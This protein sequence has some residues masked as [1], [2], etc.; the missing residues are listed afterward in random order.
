[1]HSSDINKNVMEKQLIKIELF[2]KRE[3]FTF[4]KFLIKVQKKKTIF[5]LFYSALE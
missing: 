1:M 4:F 2:L 5:F 3:Y